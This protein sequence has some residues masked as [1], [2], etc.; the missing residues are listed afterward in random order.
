M[1]IEGRLNKY[2]KSLIS[3]E[4][5]TPSLFQQELID[6]INDKLD[7][8]DLIWTNNVDQVKEFEKHLRDLYNTFMEE[9][10]VYF[11]FPI[12]YVD[13]KTKNNILVSEKIQELMANKSGIFGGDD[14]AKLMEDIEKRI[15]ECNSGR[16][17]WN[18]LFYRKDRDN[19]QPAVGID[20][21][22]H[23]DFLILYKDTKPLEA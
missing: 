10:L 19:D 18:S 9:M 15:E 14:G 17:A 12:N 20:T 3:G 16:Q 7:E 23:Q 2:A 5:K 1:G 13:E 11:E 8:Q 4:G 21:T 6:K 22:L